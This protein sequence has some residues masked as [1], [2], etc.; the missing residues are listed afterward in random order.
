VVLVFG[1]RRAVGRGFPVRAAHAPTFCISNYLLSVLL[2]R[3]YQETVR[4]TC[5]SVSFKYFFLYMQLHVTSEARQLSPSQRLGRFRI[6]YSPHIL[7]ASTNSFLIPFSAPASGPCPP[8]APIPNV[9]VSRCRN[10]ALGGSCEV[11]CAKNCAPVAGVR[12]TSTYRCVLDVQTN[13][14]TLVGTAPSCT[15]RMSCS[16]K[17]DTCGQ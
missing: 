12:P 11:E 8:L 3:L 6:L 7:R 16:L 2:S 15:Q 1:K 17:L 4:F 13:T 10:V 5:V 14:A 9:D